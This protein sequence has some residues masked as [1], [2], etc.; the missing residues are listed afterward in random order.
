MSDSIQIGSWNVRGMGDPDRAMVVCCWLQNHYPTLDILCLQELQANVSNVKFQLQ[1][2][3]PGGVVQLDMNPEGRVGST[4]L[5]SDGLKVLAQGCKGDGTFAWAQLQTDNGIIIVGSLYAPTEQQRCISFWRWLRS[6]MQTDNWIFV[7]DTYIMEFPEDSLGPS[8]VLPGAEERVWHRFQDQFNLVDLYLCASIC[9]GPV[10]TRQQQ[11][12]PWFDSARL[13][14][15]YCNNHGHWYDHVKCIEHDGRQTLSDHWPVI[16][17]IQLM[18]PATG[19][20]KKS[21]YFKF[22]SSF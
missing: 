7:G 14:R 9:K 16:A 17:T 11:S 13:D 19:A 20:L 18:P 10:F 21:S 5:I 8:T 3:T 12:G 15:I 6:F 4:L 2:I 1:T 22:D